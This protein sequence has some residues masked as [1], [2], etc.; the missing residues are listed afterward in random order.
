MFSNKT[1]A[2]KRSVKILSLTLDFRLFMNEHMSKAVAKAIGKCMALREI[3]GVRPAQ[4]RQMYMA[5]V[6][7]TTDYAPSI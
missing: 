4:M 5:A 3:R 6:V 1:I 7:P 2:L